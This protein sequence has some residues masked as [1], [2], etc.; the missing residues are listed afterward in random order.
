M[1]PLT[2][3]PTPSLTL[4]L[5]LIAKPNFNPLAINLNSNLAPKS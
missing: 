4:T 1:Q 3:N 5:I 2:L